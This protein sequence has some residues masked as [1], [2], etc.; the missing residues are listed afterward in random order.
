MKIRLL[1]YLNKEHF[2]DIPDDTELIEIRVIS[3]DMVMTSPVYYDTSDDRIMNY[4]D[5][6]FSLRREDFSLLDTVESSYDFKMKMY[7]YDD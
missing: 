3:G 7:G 6:W 5:G 2:V 1:D 4:N